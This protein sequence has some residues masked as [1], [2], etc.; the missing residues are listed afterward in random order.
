MPWWSPAL[1]GVLYSPSN[2]QGQMFTYK[3][4]LIK[5]KL[6]CIV[7]QQ[8]CILVYVLSLPLM[9]PNNVVPTTVLSALTSQRPAHSQSCS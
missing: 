7:H 3:S 4:T 8:S 5:T 2:Q 6:Y 9:H 1:T